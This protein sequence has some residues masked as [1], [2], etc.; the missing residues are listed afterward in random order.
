MGPGRRRHAREVVVQ[1]LSHVQL[2]AA[3]W[4]AACQDSLSFTISQSLLKLMSIG[5]VKLEKGVG[6][7]GFWEVLHCPSGRTVQAA[8]G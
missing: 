7:V 4:S 8:P 6:L 3:L 1:S 2:F 5:P